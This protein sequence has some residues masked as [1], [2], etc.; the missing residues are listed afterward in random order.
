MRKS[1]LTEEQMVTILRGADRTTVAEAAK[2]HKVSEPTIYAWRKH[3]GQMEAAD[4]KRLKTLE[5]KNTRLS[6]SPRRRW[7]SRC[8]RRSTR[9]NGEPAVTARAGRA[10]APAW[11]VQASSLRAVER[12][13]LVVEQR[14]AAAREGRTCDRSHE[15]AVGAVPTLRL[16]AHPDL[17]AAPGLELSW[18]HTHRIWRQA[19]LLLPKRRPRKR[20]ATGRPRAHTPYKANMVW[21][22]DFEGGGTR[23]SGR[24]LETGCCRPGPAV[25]WRPRPEAVR[26]KPTRPMAAAHF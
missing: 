22:Y 25:E 23:P 5:Q 12:V 19:G 7:A 20:I 18:S 10:G 6:C 13:A 3:F 16:P 26:R 4:V 14:A 24:R 8:S 1:R 17:P 11:P 9:E 15:G 21:A 2:E